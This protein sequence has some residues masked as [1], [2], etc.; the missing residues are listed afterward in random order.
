MTVIDCYHPIEPSIISFISSFYF[1]FLIQ[2]ISL[3]ILVHTEKL[4]SYRVTLRI[5]SSFAHCLLNLYTQHPFIY[6]Q[7]P[8]IHKQHLALYNAEYGLLKLKFSIVSQVRRFLFSYRTFLCIEE[9]K[10]EL[11]MKRTMNL[12]CSTYVKLITIMGEFVFI[13]I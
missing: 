9:A 3:D 8:F 13:D 7:H 11:Y 12:K 6:K 4:L 5:F 2:L 10:K 1:H